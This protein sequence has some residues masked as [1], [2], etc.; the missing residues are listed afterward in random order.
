MNPRTIRGSSLRDALSRVRANLGEDAVV[1]ETR[2]LP[3]RETGAGVP[4][5]ILAASAIES[6]D[7]LRLDH[8][9]TLGDVTTLLHT[10]RK[11]LR[12]LQSALPKSAITAQTLNETLTLPLEEMRATLG[13][14]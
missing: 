8:V 10:V 2:P 12:E 7:H 14:V 6:R 3:E 9:E 4:Y 11:E 1:L 13:R 5:E